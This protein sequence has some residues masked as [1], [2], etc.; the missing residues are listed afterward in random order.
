MI[1]RKITN[2]IVLLD[3]WAT[4][5]LG[6]V[7]SGAEQTE[8]QNSLRDSARIYSNAC[9]KKC[10]TNCLYHC[11][12]GV[13]EDGSEVGLGSGVSVV[14]VLYLLLLILWFFIF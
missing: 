8:G 12:G 13:D 4:E 2:I 7:L 11:V 9:I 3:G 1:P 6:T 10:Y 5:G 14:Y